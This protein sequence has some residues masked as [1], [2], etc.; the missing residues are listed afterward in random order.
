MLDTYV[1][2]NAIGYISLTFFFFFYI[3][4]LL[5]MLNNNDYL[6]SLYIYMYKLFKYIYIQM[7]QHLSPYIK[8]LLL[9][10]KYFM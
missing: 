10:F 7:F 1:I 8:P 6:N 4:L 5:I 9:F 3:F 2:F